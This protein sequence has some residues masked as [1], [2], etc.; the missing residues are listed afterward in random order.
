[1]LYTLEVQPTLI[2]EIR[3]TQNANLQLK[4]I[5]DEVLVDRDLGRWNLQVPK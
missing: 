5:K 2:E 1:M 3:T 4:R